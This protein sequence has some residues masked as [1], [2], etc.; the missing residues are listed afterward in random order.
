MV[1]VAIEQLQ[2][3]LSASRKEEEVFKDEA[4]KVQKFIP[5]LLA[6]ITPTQCFAL[7]TN[8]N[9]NHEAALMSIQSTR[10]K[11]Q[12]TSHAMYAHSILQ[13]FFKTGEIQLL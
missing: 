8:R 13:P 9:V 11:S 3:E 10:Q 7:A 1:Q 5:V 6:C 12:A 2:Q 4:R